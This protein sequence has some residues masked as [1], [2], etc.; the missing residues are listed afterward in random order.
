MLEQWFPTTQLCTKCG[1]KTK[2][3]T[4]KRIFVCDNCGLTDDRDVHAANN[5]IWF[6]LTYMRLKNIK[7][8]EGTFDTSK[9]VS[10]KSAYKISYKEFCK[11]FAAEQET[12][13]SLV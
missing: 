13:T 5:M 3:P 11:L 2:M 12:V 7:D 6:V 1:H 4:N 9:L 10:N 8:T